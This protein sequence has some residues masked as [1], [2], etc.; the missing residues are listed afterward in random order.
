MHYLNIG[1]ILTDQFRKPGYVTHFRSASVVLGV[2]LFR[3][4][5]Q[6]GICGPVYRHGIG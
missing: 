3:L 5:R 4:K 2:Y 6:D 1:I